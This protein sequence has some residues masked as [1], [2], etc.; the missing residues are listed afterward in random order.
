MRAR[1]SPERGRQA[2]G[3]AA[4][5]R[6]R[7]IPIS[8]STCR[9]AMA[10]CS[11]KRPSTGCTRPSPSPASTDARCFSRAARCWA[12]R[13]RSTA[14]SM[15]AA[16]TRI[17]IAGASAAMAAGAMTTCC[18]ISR[19]PRTRRAAPTISTA[20]AARCRFPISGIADPLSAAFIDAAAE[21]GHPEQPGFQRR[22]A[23][24]RRLFPDH[25]AARPA[26]QHRGGLS[27]PGQRPAA[28]CRSRPRRWRSAS[29]SR[30]AARSR[31]STARTAARGRRG[32]ARKSWCQAAPI[33]SPQLLQLSGVGPAELLRSHGID[34][35]LDAPGRRQRSAGSPAG[36]GGDA[37]HPAAS[38]STTSSTIR[39]AACWPARNMPRFARGR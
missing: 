13:V 35:V 3:A 25:D 19:R 7:R 12:D 34:V 32:R 39:C 11:R 37:L 5:G 22:R 33:N 17:T 23:G 30:A 6:A 2:F 10:G 26:G 18:R 38:R 28:T 29:C 8:G 20:S 24:R 27:S 21:T 14:C 4:R 31:S 1:Q 36:Q 9:S 15:S 16:S